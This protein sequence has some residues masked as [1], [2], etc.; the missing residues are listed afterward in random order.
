MFPTIRCSFSGIELDATYE[1]L[2]WV[3]N[4]WLGGF[5]SRQG[6]YS[7]T[8]EN[9]RKFMKPEEWDFGMKEKRRRLILSIPMAKKSNPKG[10]CATAVLLPNE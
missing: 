3:V 9:A 6:Y 10:Q 5:L 4:G 1:Y 7:A 8:P 2:N